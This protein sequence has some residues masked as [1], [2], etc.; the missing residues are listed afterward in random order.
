MRP[1]LNTPRGDVAGALHLVVL[2]AFAVAQPLYDLLGDTPEFF[3]VRGSTSWDLVAF[4]LGLLLVPP[5]LLL[6]AELAAGVV[7]PAA[8]RGAHL[9]FVAGLTGLIAL[10]ALNRLGEPPSALAFV[11]AAAVGAALAYAYARWGAIRT[12]VSV[13]APAPLV[14]AALFLVNSPLEEL[15]LESEAQAQE[16]SVVDARTPVVLVVLDELPVSSLMGGDGGIDRGRYPSFARLADRASW[17]RNAATV[18]EHTTEALPAILSG[19]DP[20]EGR[21]P[22]FADHPDNL[23]TFLGGSYGMHVLEP[24]TQLCPSN[25][26]P[27]AQESFAARMTSLGRDVAVI[28]GH[29][30]L[31]A[32]VGRR[33]PS[34]TE[35]WQDFGKEHGNDDAEA[36]ELVVHD[37]EDVDRAVGQEL[38][39]DQRSEIERYIERIRPTARPTLHVLHEMLPHSPWRFLPSGRQYGD[40]L[41]IDGIADDRW[42]TDEWLVQQGWQRHLLQVGLVDRL[43]GDLLDRL[44]ETGLYD[45]SLVIVTADHGVSFRPGDRRRGI[46]PT[47]VGDIALVPFFVKRPGQEEGAIVDRQVWTT[48]IVPTIADALGTPLPYTADGRSVFDPSGA[49]SEVAVHERF[50]GAV[51][52]P[53]SEAHRIRDETVAH[54]AAIFG[55]GDMAGLY[56]FG[57]DRDL[58]GRTPAE[59]PSVPAI[60]IE[61]DVDNEALLADVDPASALSPA[62]V[63]GQL[64]GAAA[65]AGVPLA[66]AVN[67]RIAGVTRSFRTG[68]TITFSAYLPDSAFRAGHNDVEVYAVRRPGGRP[69]LAL[70]GTS[71]TSRFALVREAGDELVERGDGTRVPLV[72]GAVDGVVEDWF[73]ERDSVRFGGWAGDVEGRLPADRVLVFAGD[74]LIGSG[75]P[76]V[77]RADLGKRFPGLGRSGFVFDLPLERVGTEAAPVRLRFV[78]IRGDTASELAYARAFPW[79]PGR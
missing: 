32:G 23:F 40:A 11:L 29:V 2:S 16:L 22:L 75:T 24:V 70:L 53:A 74:E 33:L 63:T 1:R 14:F 60:G 46:T 12:V 61:A 58:V 78:G 76:R 13:L 6:L 20:E 77:G 27:R 48:D 65:A 59:L 73:V 37:D 54:Q 21:L 68:S 8:Q 66:V 71:A 52:A 45:R 25:L 51:T 36:K 19:L 47:N 4:A 72:P 26:C 42:G 15:S 43:L 79:Q 35:T 41:G 69:A 28:Y 62:H 5:A 38:W 57:P 7:H 9:T 56:A 64:D 18:H 3:V 10:Q 30:V 34:V 49:R 44:E 39:Q 31:P 67:G 17:F 55:S 50:G